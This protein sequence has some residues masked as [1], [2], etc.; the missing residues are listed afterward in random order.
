ML[1]ITPCITLCTTSYTHRAPHRAS[2]HVA[3]IAR[4]Q[5][6]KDSTT[7]LSRIWSG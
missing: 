5:T 2:H 7:S 4:S 3:C 6:H 1:C